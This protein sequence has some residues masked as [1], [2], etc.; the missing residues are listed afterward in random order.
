MCVLCVLCVCVCVTASISVWQ[1][2]ITFGFLRIFIIWRLLSIKM[3]Q[4]LQ[5]ML[6][7]IG[8]P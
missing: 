6:L 1:D 7:R 5:N 2:A 8:R 3:S 4:Q